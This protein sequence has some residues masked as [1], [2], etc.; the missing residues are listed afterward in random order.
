V[1]GSGG[2]VFHIGTLNGRL[3]GQVK[4]SEKWLLVELP[5]GNPAWNDALLQRFMA[6]C[7]VN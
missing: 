2:K 5:A 1:L 4:V 6:S 7:S 3:A